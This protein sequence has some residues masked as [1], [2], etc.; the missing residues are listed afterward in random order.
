MGIED[1]ALGRNAW[2]DIEEIEVGLR[3]TALCLNCVRVE[4]AKLLGP[5]LED[6][7]LICACPLPKPIL[8][9]HP[10]KPLD[11]YRPFHGIR[12]DLTIQSF[13]GA[14]KQ[15]LDVRQQ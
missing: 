1:V 15:S 2:Y 9:K 13:L 11:L 8:C 6:V 3:E 4:S 10:G 12:I 14:R 7:N 5:E